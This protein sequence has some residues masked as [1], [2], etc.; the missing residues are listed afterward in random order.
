[1]NNILDVIFNAQN[2]N[3]VGQMARDFGLND[4]QAADVVRQVTPA[5]A[6]G[7]RNNVADD[8]G[9]SDLLSAIKKGNHDRY[10]DQ[11]NILTRKETIDDG[12][13]I[14]GHIF[15][16]KDVSRNVARN[17]SKQTGISDSI[18]K[19][20]LPVIAA[21]VM[22]SLSKKVESLGG[23]VMGSTRGTG[24]QAPDS[25]SGGLGS[26]IGGFLDADQDGSMLD[27]LLGMAGRF[28]R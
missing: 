20:M 2:G 9:L 19:K 13:D 12:N 21:M 11:P 1:M 22:G 23:D 26:I 10:V 4:S 28:M 24:T 8:N 14:L 27:D 7:V 6:R 16:T 15:G 17:A 25:S 5:M 18:I 3:A